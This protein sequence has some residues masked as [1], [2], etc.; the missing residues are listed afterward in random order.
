MKKV[1]QALEQ[2]SGVRKQAAIQVVDD[3]VNIV[4]C[5]TGALDTV[6]ETLQ[7]LDGEYASHCRDIVYLVTDALGECSGSLEEALELLR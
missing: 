7:S 6:Y 2:A 4:S 5:A 3:A 1:R